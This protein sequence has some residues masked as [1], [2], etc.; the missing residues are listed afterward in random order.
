MQFGEQSNFLLTIYFVY[1]ETLENNII[2]YIKWIVF[3]T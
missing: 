1:L 2:H 3:N